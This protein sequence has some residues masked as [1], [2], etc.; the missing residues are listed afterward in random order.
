MTS[1][2]LFAAQVR[3]ARQL[4]TPPMTQAS[5][6]DLSGVAEMTIKKI[7]QLLVEPKPETIRKV[8]QGLKSAGVSVVQTETDAEGK[9]SVRFIL[10]E[11][12]YSTR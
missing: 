10:P 12:F 1:P 7:E 5:L 6:A 2:K 11:N 3:A 4:F 9:L 8:T